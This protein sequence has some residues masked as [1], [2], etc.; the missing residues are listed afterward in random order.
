MAE[1]GQPRVSPSSREDKAGRPPGAPSTG[2]MELS[3]RP[4]VATKGPPFHTRDSA[5]VDAPGGAPPPVA[6]GVN[7]R[8]EPELDA[9]AAA[10]SAAVLPGAGEPPDRPTDMR[11][12]RN[13]PIL[14]RTDDQ[15]TTTP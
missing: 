6:D 11:R 2:R 5:S 12:C 9:L 1:V 15:I 3:N 8:G 7:R 4:G 13:E 14:P 10:Q